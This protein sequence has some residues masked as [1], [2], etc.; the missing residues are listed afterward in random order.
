MV[1]TES[2]SDRARDNYYAGAQLAPERR[3]CHIALISDRNAPGTLAS[4]LAKAKAKREQKVQ[5]AEDT[6]ASKR[7]NVISRGAQRIREI[8]ELKVELDQEE[9]DLVG[10]VGNP[11][12]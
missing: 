5:A 2:R 6:Y 4:E 12:A 10:V 9:K 1:R 7:S 11:E 3:C 8:R